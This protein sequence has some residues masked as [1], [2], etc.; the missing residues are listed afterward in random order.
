MSGDLADSQDKSAMK[1]DSSQ[2]GV[3]AKKPDSAGSRESSNANGEEISGSTD[4][5]TKPERWRVE[6]DDG[7]SAE[8]PPEVPISSINIKPAGPTDSA[9]SMDKTKSA[10]AEHQLKAIETA[11]VSSSALAMTSERQA[12]LTSKLRSALDACAPLLREIMTD[13]HSFLQ[14]TLLGTHGQEIMNDSRGKPSL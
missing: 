11:E 7:S 8:P 2:S 5:Q 3:V 9:S 13:F 12:S 6:D 1:S 10:A 14:R 4:E